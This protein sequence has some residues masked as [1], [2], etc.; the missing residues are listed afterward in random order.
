MSDGLERYAAAR[1]E[2][3]ATFDELHELLAPAATWHGAAADLDELRTGGRLREALRTGVVG[4][5]SSGKSFL[6]NALSGSRA[7]T[8]QWEPHRRPARNRHQPSTAAMQARY[9]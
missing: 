8:N 9:G 3:A 4:E 2:V 7:T 5:F 1:D 6:L